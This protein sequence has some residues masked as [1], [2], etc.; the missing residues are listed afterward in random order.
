MELQLK[1]DFY[2]CKSLSN[3]VGVTIARKLLFAFFRPLLCLR[4]QTNDCQLNGICGI[5]QTTCNTGR[6]VITTYQHIISLVTV[7]NN[8]FQFQCHSHFR[9]SHHSKSF[10]RDFV[11]RSLLYFIFALLFFFYLNIRLRILK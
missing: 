11:V 7:L 8:H 6:Y 2:H 5:S 1:Y 9:F 10:T 4:V 3:S